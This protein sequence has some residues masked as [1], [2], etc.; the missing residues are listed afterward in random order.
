MIYRLLADGVILLHLLFI[1]FM[2]TGSLLA[3]RYWWMPL[4][5]LPA[6]AWAVALTYFGWTCPLTPLENWLRREGGQA[7]YEEGF[8]A[9]Y[10]LPV[11]YPPGLQGQLIWL[12]LGA[13]AINLV[14]YGWVLWR[15]RR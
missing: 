14:G 8:I 6:V 15:R 9:H 2:V 11:I 1:V 13:L 4:L 10:L 5:H 12:A 3:L 7:G